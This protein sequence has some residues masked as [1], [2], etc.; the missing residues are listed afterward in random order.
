MWLK[1]RHHWT[2]D[3]SWILQGRLPYNMLGNDQFLAWIPFKSKQLKTCPQ[4]SWCSTPFHNVYLP[5]LWMRFE[6]KLSHEPIARSGANGGMALREVSDNFGSSPLQRQVQ[7]NMPSVYTGV[8]ACLYTRTHGCIHTGYCESPN[9]EAQNPQTRDGVGRCPSNTIV[10]I[11]R[12]TSKQT[13]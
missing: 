11:L 8:Q 4:Q 12:R 2:T 5:L 7:Q 3:I 1:I 6:Q 10:V 9:L 13:E